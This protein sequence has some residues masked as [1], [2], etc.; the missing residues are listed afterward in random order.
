MR[1]TRIKKPS[2]HFSQMNN[3]F[4][5]RRFSNFLLY[6]L[7]NL[8]SRHYNEILLM[9]LLPLM[10]GFI[11]MSLNLFRGNPLADADFSTAR[12]LT[13]A[14]VLIIP[15]FFPAK[16]YGFL[17]DRKA[18][19]N[20]TL[21][22]ASHFEK[23]LAMLIVLLLVVPAAIVL[24]LF[25]SDAIL[26]TAFHAGYGEG[27][28]ITLLR[29]V[30]ASFICLALAG[31]VNTCLVFLLGSLCFKK[32]KVAK[33]FLACFLV[34]VVLTLVG[35]IFGVEKLGDQ[36][37]SAILEIDVENINLWLNIFIFGFMALFAGMVFYRLKTIKY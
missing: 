4:S 20:W 17:T 7:K 27:V 25:C 11:T 14:M 37:M 29:E 19:A 6:E 32:A 35:N 18:G 28:I 8:K 15:L 33:T 21:I 26:A 9:G 24:L 12:S 23:Y 2:K 16:V 30:P 3:I 5:F 13:F 22:P 1:S 34:S 36:M 31:Y 10:M